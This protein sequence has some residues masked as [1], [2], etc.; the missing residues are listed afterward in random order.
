MALLTITH[1]VLLCFDVVSARVCAREIEREIKLRS[2]SN[3]DTFCIVFVGT[4]WE[5]IYSYILLTNN[6]MMKILV[7][8][9]IIFCKS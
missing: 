9:Y 4:V 2:Q 6:L 3:T 7:S 1:S 5:G 8:L